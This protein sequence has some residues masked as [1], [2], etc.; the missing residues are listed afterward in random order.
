MPKLRLILSACLAIFALTSVCSCSPTYVIRA[1]WEEGKILSKREYIKTLIEKS[2]DSE[3]K[4]KLIL[5][6]NVREFSKTIGLKPE[7]SFTYYSKLDKKVLVWVLS[8][9]KKTEFTP[10]TWWF[11]I[12]GSVP[13]KGFFEKKD[14]LRAFEKLKKKNYDALLRPSSAFSTL[15]WFNDPVL[16][17]TLKLD[18]LSIAN[19]VVHEIVHSTLW[20]KNSV[21]FNETLANFVGSYGSYQYFLSIK[22]YESAQQ[23]LE[24]WEDEVLYADFLS[25]LKKELKKFY[26]QSK[27]NNR[28]EEVILIERE[29]IFKD[30]YVNWKKLKSSFK[31]KHFQTKELKINNAVILSEL[32]YL[33]RPKIFEKLYKA[34][35]NSLNCVIEQ[36]QVVATNRKQYKDPFLG[37][38]EVSKKIAEISK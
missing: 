18:N 19:T 7:K 3:L 24:G 6:E 17:S 16:S 36:C 5:V 32:V 13:Y 4:E 31:T 11:P 28:T 35:N 14:A 10:K 26:I 20:V 12:V 37:V 30:A 33:D 23:A 8:G 2:K 21:S 38:V 29:K 9:S 15:G 1:A 27:S 22:D 34:C 25:S